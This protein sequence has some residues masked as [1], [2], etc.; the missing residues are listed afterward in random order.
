MHSCTQTMSHYCKKP[1]K[2]TKTGGGRQWEG[3]EQNRKG[4]E[5]QYITIQIVLKAGM[6]VSSQC[7][8]A[9]AQ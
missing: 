1:K 3:S 9:M 8:I 7:A 6:S 4:K 2:D 5:G